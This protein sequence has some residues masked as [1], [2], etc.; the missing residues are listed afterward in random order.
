MEMTLNMNVHT[1]SPLTYD[2]LMVVDGGGAVGN[3]LKATAGS[4]LIAWSP[5]IGVGVSMVATPAAG[6]CAGMSA[7]GLG[8]SLIGSATH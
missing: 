7:A 5:V 6:V 8:L 2:E 1:F 3:A 4:V